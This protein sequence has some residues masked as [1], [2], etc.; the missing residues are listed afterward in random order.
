ML[1]KEHIAFVLSFFYTS[2]IVHAY[3]IKMD[4]D[5]SFNIFSSSKE[6]GAR[7]SNIHISISPISL[8]FSLMQC[9]VWTYIK[10]RANAQHF[11]I[12]NMKKV[13]GR[14]KSIETYVKLNR[15]Q[16]F[17]QV[18]MLAWLSCSISIMHNQNAQNEIKELSNVL[19]QDILESTLVVMVCFWPG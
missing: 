13:S 7:D 2:A 14:C 12:S 6:L 10:I 3:V 19:P 4:F 1:S 18:H 15:A 16:K 8:K 5:A 11:K 9:Y 17:I